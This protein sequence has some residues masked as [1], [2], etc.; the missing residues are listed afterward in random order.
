MFAIWWQTRCFVWTLML[1]VRFYCIHWRHCCTVIQ[2]VVVCTVHLVKLFLIAEH[3]SSEQATDKKVA[4]DTLRMESP[5]G[6]ILAPCLFSIYISDNPTTLSTKL[7]YTDDLA[8]VFTG[9]FRTG[10]TSR[11]SWTGTCQHSTPTTIKIGFNLAKK[12]LCMP[13][14][15]LTHVTWD[16]DKTFQWMTKP[17]NL[18]QTQRIL[19]WSSTGRSPSSH[20][21]HLCGRRFCHAARC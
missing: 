12:K 15:I 13:C 5:Q 10:Q 17:S 9:P 1:F 2:V 4:H 18:N 11:T 8:L 3:L 6:S 7:A 21:L 20:I 19:E 14:T 16:D